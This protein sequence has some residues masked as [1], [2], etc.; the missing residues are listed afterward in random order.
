MRASIRPVSA[1]KHLFR[2]TRTLTLLTAVS[3]LKTP[4]HAED[5]SAQSHEEMS[6]WFV[7]IID[8]LSLLQSLA[9]RRDISAEHME[10]LNDKSRDMFSASQTLEIVLWCV[11]HALVDPTVRT[12]LVNLDGQIKQRRK[13]RQQ[14]HYRHFWTI[15]NMTRV[16]LSTDQQTDQGDGT[17]LFIDLL[18]E[19]MTA[20]SSIESDHVT[21]YPSSS[22]SALVEVFKHT[23]ADLIVKKRCVLLYVLYDL[24]LSAALIEDFAQ[25]FMIDQDY[26]L[27]TRALWLL[28]T[29]QFTEAVALL[30]GGAR[31]GA[32]IELE[33][34]TRLIVKTLHDYEQYALAL[35]VITANNYL[36]SHLLIGHQ[37]RDQ[38]TGTDDVITYID[39]LLYNN[40]LHQAFNAVVSTPRCPYMVMLSL[41]HP[42][43][44]ACHQSHD[45]RRVLR[46]RAVGDSAVPP[47]PLLSHAPQARRAL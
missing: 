33:Q 40:L 22:L 32:K 26:Q 2:V 38:I 1:V 5:Q 6:R 41:T 11:S 34:W 9:S 3:A 14:R 25:S 20:T 42:P 4:L 10:L 35:R 28:D 44:A 16:N 43:L 12:S 29:Q 17:K 19:S 27:L 13:D 18:W 23:H 8:L 7:L 39:V 31:H 45:T 15:K 21:S 30:T 47:L 24:Q 36:Q 46:S 37:S